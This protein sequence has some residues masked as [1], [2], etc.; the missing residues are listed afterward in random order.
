ITEA[1]FAI[2][3]LSGKVAQ[4]RQTSPWSLIAS[5]LDLLSYVTPPSRD[6]FPFSAK[7]VRAGDDPKVMLASFLD[8]RLFAH[9]PHE[10][11]YRAKLN[12][13]L[14]PITDFLN[15][16]WKESHTPTAAMAQS[17]CI[18]LCRCPEKV[19]MLR[20]LRLP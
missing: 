5:H 7:D 15:D 12:P 17:L 6:D 9:E 16:H 11:S 10:P 13:V 14:V 2:Y 19:R 18:D 1:M 20:Q 4:H 8:S 3:S